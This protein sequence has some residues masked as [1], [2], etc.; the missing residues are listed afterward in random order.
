M[1]VKVNL[2]QEEIM[3]HEEHKTNVLIAKVGTFKLTSSIV[4]IPVALGTAKKL[5]L[6]GNILFSGGHI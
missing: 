3:G 5:E 6:T 1:D 2:C 4:Y